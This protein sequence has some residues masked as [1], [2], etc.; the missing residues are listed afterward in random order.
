MKKIKDFKKILIILSI[1]AIA[2]FVLHYVMYK[3]IKFKNEKISNL[4]YDLSVLSEKQ[5][6]IIAADRTFQKLKG[7]LVIASNSVVLKEEDV[8]FIENIE[9]IARRNGLT[10]EIE[11]IVLE[12]QKL[13]SSDLVVMNIKAK[14]VGG[15]SGSYNFLAELE[16]LP[17]KVKIKRSSLI[18][19]SADSKIE[20]QEAVVS[21]GLWK[22]TIDISVLKYK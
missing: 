18:N 12:N 1:S 22:S 19:S 9:S 10:I 13:P 21:N 8:K 5:D 16:S 2:I 14:T 7:D 20:G 4:Q 17:I 3:D 15:W 11:S 6:Y